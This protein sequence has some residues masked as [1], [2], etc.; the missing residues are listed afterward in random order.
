MDIHGDWLY[1][2]DCKLPERRDGVGT[3]RV[4]VSVDLWCLCSLFCILKR[5]KECLSSL[6]FIFVVLL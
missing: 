2:Q 6:L 4:W 3:V 5:N 1:S